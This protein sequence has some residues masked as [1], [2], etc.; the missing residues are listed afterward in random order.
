MDDGISNKK[1][2]INLVIFLSYFLLMMLIIGV[3]KCDSNK[4]EKHLDECREIC[5]PKDIIE[6]FSKKKCLCKEP[7][8]IE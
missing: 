2:S 6:T 5:K 8:E 3:I 4:I 7:I 1:I